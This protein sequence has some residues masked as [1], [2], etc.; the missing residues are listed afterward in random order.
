MGISYHNEDMTPLLSEGNFQAFMHGCN[1]ICTMGAGIAR[2]V[3]KIFPEAWKADRMTGKG[4]RKK[5]G[6]IGVVE[7]DG[8]IV[9]NA[10]T[11]YDIH[12]PAPR[13]S[14]DAIRSCFRDAFAE[15]GK[16]GI[17][18]LVIPKIGAGLAGGDW[19]TIEKII[20]DEMPENILVKVY[21]L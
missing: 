21:Y 14:Y 19:G 13:C 1:C 2:T 11:Q 17:T 20:L 4:D 16:R 10:Y 9:I 7:R 6:T 8:K 18:E 5:L 15:M 12:G 3:K